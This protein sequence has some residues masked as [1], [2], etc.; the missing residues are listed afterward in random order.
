EPAVGRGPLERAVGADLAADLLRDAAVRGPAPGVGGADR[1]QHEEPD[2]KRFHV[3][4]GWLRPAGSIAAG[5]RPEA[6]RARALPTPGP[7]APITPAAQAAR[8]ALGIRSSAGR[9]AGDSRRRRPPRAS[10]SRL[11]S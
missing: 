9:P 1:Q 3:A 6:A 5:R 7:R 10:G 11:R 2:E 4:S 8:A